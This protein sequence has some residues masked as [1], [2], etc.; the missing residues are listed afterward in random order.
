MRKLIIVLLLG[1]S[2]NT[3]RNGNLIN[4]MPSFD[5]YEEKEILDSLVSYKQKLALL[6]SSGDA[7]AINSYGYMGKYQ[8]SKKLLR[9]L[10]FSSKEIEEFVY[11]DELQERAIDTLTSHNMEVLRNYGLIPHVGSKVDGITITMNGMLAG[12]HLR[13]PYSVKQYIE[14]KGSIDLADGYGT[15]VS[16][17]LKSF[18]K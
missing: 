3:T 18:D 13:G 15:K 2:F 12:A 16:D 8:F 4:S 11:S 9:R 7:R 1:L 5:C 6:E 10:N 17:Y 14:S